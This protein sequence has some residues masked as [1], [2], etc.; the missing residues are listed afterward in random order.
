M[1]WHLEDFIVMES[2]EP[3]IIFGQLD[4]VCEDC[5]CPYLAEHEEQNEIG[6]PCPNCLHLNSL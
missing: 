4:I 5:N 2:I 6:Y 3:G 1:N